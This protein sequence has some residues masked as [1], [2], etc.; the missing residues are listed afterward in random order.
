MRISWFEPVPSEPEEF[1]EYRRG[2]VVLEDAFTFLKQLLEL[3]KASVAKNDPTWIPNVHR[4]KEGV[5]LEWISERG[6]YTILLPTDRRKPAAFSGRG[7]RF[8]TDGHFPRKDVEK[9]LHYWRII[10]CFS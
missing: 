6:I 2:L 7:D 3:S 5:E 8:T 1:T 4:T 9:G 10:H